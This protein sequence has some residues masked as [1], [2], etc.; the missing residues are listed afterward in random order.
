M[1]RCVRRVEQA[2]TDAGFAATGVRQRGR[3]GTGMDRNQR[4]RG[5]ARSPEG[6][7]SSNLRVLIHERSSQQ[8][9]LGGTDFAPA[10]CSR[11][12]PKTGLAWRRHPQPLAGWTGFCASAASAAMASVA[13]G[14]VRF[15]GRCGGVV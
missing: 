11:L 7:L 8:L 1:C 4:A 10:G 14:A 12:G 13:S 9:I 2:R 15:G 5:A 3:Y 6:E